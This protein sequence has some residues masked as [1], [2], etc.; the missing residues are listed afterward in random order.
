MRTHR[1]LGYSFLLCPVL[2]P[3]VTTP[4]FSHFVFSSGSY[5]SKCNWWIEGAGVLIQFGPFAHT[6]AESS[7][8]TVSRKQFFKVYFFC[9][10]F[11]VKPFNNW[12]HLQASPQIRLFSQGP[13]LFPNAHCVA[14]PLPVWQAVFHQPFYFLKAESKKMLL[15][16]GSPPTVF[17]SSL[18]TVYKQTSRRRK[19]Y[20]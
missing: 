5:S 10:C 12:T 1:P 3:A 14:L 8:N 2:T 18:P 6:P 15:C 7:T 19:A 4:S 20:K 9:K 11:K 17:T 13:L 16:F